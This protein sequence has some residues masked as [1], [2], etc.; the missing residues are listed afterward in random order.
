ML[1]F[2][3]AAHQDCIHLLGNTVKTVI[4]LDIITIPINC[5]QFIYFLECN[6]FM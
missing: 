4:L 5:F 3:Q 1:W 6:L 2:I